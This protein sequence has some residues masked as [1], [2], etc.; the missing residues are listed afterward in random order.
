LT[1]QLLRSFSF[2]GQTK[3]E[4]A[5]QTQQDNTVAAINKMHADIT[6]KLLQAGIVTSGHAG[7]SGGDGDGGNEGDRNGGRG[8]NNANDTDNP[9]G[10]SDSLPPA[11]PGASGTTHGASD[12]PPTGGHSEVAAGTREMHGIV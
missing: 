10:T 9:P 4:K 7:N 11:H 6:A 1:R 3:A 2:G 12:S 8:G 5:A